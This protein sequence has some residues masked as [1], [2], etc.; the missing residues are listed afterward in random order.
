M[1]LAISEVLGGHQHPWIDAGKEDRLSFPALLLLSWKVSV[2]GVQDLDVVP[3]H[4]LLSLLLLDQLNGVTI[5]FVLLH[6]SQ[7]LFQLLDP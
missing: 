1:G 5:W 7:S 2:L 3:V 6:Q 4:D